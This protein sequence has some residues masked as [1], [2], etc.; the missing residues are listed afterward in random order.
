MGGGGAFHVKAR[1]EEPVGSSTGDFPGEQNRTCISIAVQFG[2]KDF[3]SNL[4]QTLLVREPRAWDQYQFSVPTPERFSSTD[5]MYLGND[6][7]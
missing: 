4:T 2:R 5:W 3:L 1:H 7:T 6:E